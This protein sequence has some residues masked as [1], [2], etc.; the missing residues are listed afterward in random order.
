MDCAGSRNTSCRGTG[1]KVTKSRKSTEVL[2]DL[3]G[4]RKLTESKMEGQAMLPLNTLI[5]KTV[6]R[7]L[8]LLWRGR[9]FNL[10]KM[11]SYLYVLLLLL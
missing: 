5:R 11:S 10:A 3:E 4:I 9:K 2:M 1:L 7:W 8:L 6:S